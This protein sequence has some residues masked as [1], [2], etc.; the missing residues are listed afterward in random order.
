MENQKEIQSIHIVLA[1][2][3]STG[4]QNFQK[5]LKIALE[6][7]T[8]EQEKANGTEVVKISLS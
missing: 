4:H 6:N 1:M 7:T 2:K 5:K 8:Y 3:Q